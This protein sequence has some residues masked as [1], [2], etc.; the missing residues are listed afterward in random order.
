MPSETQTSV[1][2]PFRY[3]LITKNDLADIMN[4]YK[5]KLLLDVAKCENNIIIIFLSVH[6]R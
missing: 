4:N 3:S 5:L 1:L 2:L 6:D